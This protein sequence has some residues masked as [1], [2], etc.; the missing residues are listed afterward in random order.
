MKE[1]VLATPQQRWTALQSGLILG[2][3]GVGIDR[4][5]VPL[6]RGVPHP[7]CPALQQHRWQRV[8]GGVASRHAEPHLHAVPGQWLPLQHAAQRL[9][10]GPRGCDGDRIPGG[11]DIGS[12][13]VRRSK[14]A[15][16][17]VGRVGHPRA[18]DCGCPAHRHARLSVPV[19]HQTLRNRHADL[20][21]GGCLACGHLHGRSERSS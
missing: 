20:P 21:L 4:L 9:G 18:D 10:H 19:A 3:V 13:Q 16:K 8:R 6:R 11:Q 15:C 7:D 14:V 17:I 5:V 1:E 2:A 12:M